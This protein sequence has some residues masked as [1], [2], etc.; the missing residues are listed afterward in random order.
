MK[1]KVEQ[2]K[3]RAGKL[4]SGVI[5]RHFDYPASLKVCIELDD[6][7]GVEY[8]LIIAIE[9]NPNSRFVRFSRKMDIF[10]E[11]GRID[12]D[13]LD[14]LPVK[15]ILQYWNDGNLYV[16]SLCIDYDEEEDEVDEED[17]Y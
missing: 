16:S 9:K 4:Y 14:G 7:P 12:T 15:A 5:T 3:I 17:E 1:Y 13:L 6:E 10:D 2:S 8:F 11:N